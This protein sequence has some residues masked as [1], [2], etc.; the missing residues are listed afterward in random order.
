M[1]AHNMSIE[2]RHKHAQINFLDYL[3]ILKVQAYNR[4]EFIFI[5]S[6][7]LQSFLRGDGEK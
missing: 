4:T 6:V 2:N 1:R 5:H 3:I 7:H